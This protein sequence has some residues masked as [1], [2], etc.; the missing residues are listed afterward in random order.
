V[1]KGTEIFDDR[2]DQGK[3]G[4]KMHYYGSGQGQRKRE[5]KKKGIQDDGSTI[6]KHENLLRYQSMHDGYRERGTNHR[7]TRLGFC[8]FGALIFPY[9]TSVLFLLR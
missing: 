2:D 1:R 5:Q 8:T 3:E 6:S 7:S 4:R 9:D